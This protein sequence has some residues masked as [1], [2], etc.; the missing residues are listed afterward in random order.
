MDPD[1]DHGLDRV[2]NLDS[3]WLGQLLYGEFAHHAIL[4]GLID[5]AG[6]VPEPSAAL[7]LGGLAAA[8][9]SRRGS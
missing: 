2:Y 9:P 3:H 6:L 1:P 7:L 8:A 4:A 5:M